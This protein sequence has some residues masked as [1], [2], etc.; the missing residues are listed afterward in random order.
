MNILVLVGSTRRGSINARLAGAAVQELPA[1]TTVTGFDLTTLP[2]Y[3][4]DRDAAGHSG[5]TVTEFRAAVAAAD[6]LLI[7]SPAY[8][9]GM[10][11]EV[12]NAIDTASRPRGAAVIAGKPVG[13]LTAPLSPK[14][15][16]TVAEQLTLTLRI[17]GARPLPAVIAP[18]RE[19]FDAQDRVVDALRV[20][21]DALATALVEAIERS[22][23]A[24]A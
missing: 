5:A 11:A 23:T 21:L 9:G 1:G 18:G 13:L 24:A 20:E 8:N 12:K 6:G 7:A 2:F 15:G 17:A 3:D 10:A 22:D 14:T 16:P 4:A 19:S